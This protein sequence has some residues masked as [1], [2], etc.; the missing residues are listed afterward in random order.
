MEPV[1]VVYAGTRP[2]AA[3]AAERLKKILPKLFDKWNVY[4]LS[5]FEQATPRLK[6]GV[7][8]VLGGDGTMLRAAR[9]VDSSDVKVVGVNFGRVGFLCVAEPAELE[10]VVEKIASD[11]YR[12]EKVMRL[13]VYV[14][15]SFFSEAL[16][17]TYVSST[18]PGTV[19]EYRIQQ[20]EVLASD[21]ADGVILATPIGSTA[22]AFSSGGPIVDER[23]ETVVVVPNASMTNLRPMVFSI[24]TPLTVSVV[25]GE[26]QALVDGHALR[27]FGKGVVRVE[28]SP[29]SLSMLAFD[30]QRLFSRRLRK[31]LYGKP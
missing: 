3:A 27:V 29:H 1:T 5:E 15:D 30:E 16:N 11:N 22:Y 8:I 7:M 31:R 21:V 12:V 18:R 26:A 28:K 9:H 14:N 4:S 10:E 6:E 19:V 2:G 13:A 20:R 17:E 24:E 23:L 25:K